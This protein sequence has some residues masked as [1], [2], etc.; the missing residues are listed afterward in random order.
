M[1]HVLKM[2]SPFVLVR[3][4]GNKSSMKDEERDRIDMEVKEF[5]QACM[6]QANRV[7]ELINSGGTSNEGIKEIK[8]LR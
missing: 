5:L 2:S 1:V 7:R 6:S 8:Q 3:F 4:L